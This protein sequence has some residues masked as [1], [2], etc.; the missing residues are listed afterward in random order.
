MLV[1]RGEV[2][3]NSKCVF[4]YYLR[5]KTS[6]QTDLSCYSPSKNATLRQVFSTSIRVY[7]TAIRRLESISAEEHA[8]RGDVNITGIAVWKIE[9]LFEVMNKDWRRACFRVVASCVLEIDH[10]KTRYFFIEP[11]PLVD[12][13]TVPLQKPS[14]ERSEQDPINRKIEGVFSPSGTRNSF[15]SSDKKSLTCHDIARWNKWNLPS[16]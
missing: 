7:N 8:K 2:R 11:L 9:D 10:L 4:T 12:C 1:L 13:S 14:F 5:M 15:C 16:W 6:S 3:S